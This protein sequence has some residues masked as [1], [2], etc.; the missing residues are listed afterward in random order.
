MKIAL[1]S[2]HGGYDYKQAILA[3]L[4]KEGYQVI[5]C[6]T[7]SKESCDYPQFAFA[8]AQKVSTKEADYG[9][10]I[11]TTGEGIMM[12][13][14][15]VEHV[16]CSIGYNDEVTILSRQHNNANMIAFGQKFM[17]LEDV[18]RRVDL[19]LKTEFEGG[20]HANRVNLINQYHD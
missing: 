1:G 2:D 8:A 3:H 6:G 5:D 18:I 16:R 11:C 10:L 20:R 17:A 9:I 7:F 4:L 15:K 12:A 19:F 14:N 13:A